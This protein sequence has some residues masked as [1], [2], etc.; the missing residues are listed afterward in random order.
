CFRAND[1]SVD[2]DWEDRATFTSSTLYLREVDVGAVAGVA[3]GVEMTGDATIDETGIITISNDAVTT[4]KIGTE[5]AAHANMVLTTDA[6]AAR[7][8][9]RL[10]SLTSSTLGPRAIFA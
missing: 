3:Q 5:G 9:G 2:P 8:S 4:D 6:A 1:A 10:S 7:D